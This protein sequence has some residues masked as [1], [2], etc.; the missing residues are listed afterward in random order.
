MISSNINK[1]GDAYRSLSY[2]K[3]YS[4]DNLPYRDANFNS[5]YVDEVRSQYTNGKRNTNGFEDDNQYCIN[6]YRLHGTSSQSCINS[7]SS[8]IYNEPRILNA[9]QSNPTQYGIFMHDWNDVPCSPTVLTTNY[10][11]INH[12]SSNRNRKNVKL[13]RKVNIRRHR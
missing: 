6:N 7:T 10:A 5:Y 1:N 2:R 13:K 9:N 11:E 3:S 12:K 8:F 4:E